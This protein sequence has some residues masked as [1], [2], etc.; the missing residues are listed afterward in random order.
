MFRR[1]LHS[2]L[3]FS[4]LLLISAGALAQPCPD[5]S[6]VITGPGVVSNNQLGVIYSTPNIPGHTYAWTVTGGTIGSGAG[7]NQITVNWGNIGTGTITLTETNPAANCS[8]TVNKSVSIRPL[9]I[10]YF[11]YTNTSC[12]GD[13]VSF[14]DASVADASNPV[15]TWYWTFGD[16][17]TST[18]QNPQHQYMSPFNVTYTVRLVVTNTTAD[19]DTIIDA[20]YVN[21]DQFIPHPKFTSVI[22]NCLYTPVQFNST[23]STTPPGTGNIIGWDWNFDDPASGASNTSTLQN[24][25]HVFTAPGTYLIYLQVTNE[26][27]CNN[28]TTIQIIIEP[29]LPV[30][31]Y[32]YSTPTCLDNPIYF[33]DLSTTPPGR[34]MVT[35]IWNFGDATAPVVINAPNN[36]DIVHYFPGLGPYP[37]TITVINNLG[38]RDSI[39]KSIQ[40]DPSPLADFSY[41]A[42]CVGDTVPFTNLSIQN[43]G[44]EIVS[45]Y[46]NFDDPGSGFNTSTLENP[47]HLFSAVD[48]YDVMLVT[49]NSTGCPDTVIKPVIVFDS[50]DVDFTWNFGSQNNEIHFHIDTIVTN[51]E[52]IGDMCLWNFGDGDWGYGHNP[53]H[54]YAAAGTFWVTLFVTDTVGCTN[55]ITYPVDVPSVPV[56]FFSSTSPVCDGQEVCFT[57]LSSV[58]SPPFGYIVTWIW[59]YGDVSPQD[60]INFPDDPN[61]CHL[62]ATADTFAVTLKVIDNN[63]YVDSTTANVIIKPNPIANFVYSTACQNQVVN[64]TDMSTPNGGGNI[65]SWD[66]NFA[67]PGSGINNTSALQNPTHAFSN[68]DS[69]YLVRLIIVNFNDCRDTIIKPVYVFPA[70]PVDFTHDT[71]CLN[72]LVTFT[73]DTTVTY[74]DSIATWSWD[75]GDGTPLVTDPITTQHLYTVAGVYTVTLSVIDYHGCENSVSHTV[76]V[77]PLPVANY[78][79]ASP[80]CQGDSVLFTDQSY[81]PPGFTGYIAKWLWDFGDGITQTIITPASPNVYHTFIGPSTTFTVRLTVWSNDSC[82]MFIEQTVSLIPAPDANFD[83]SSTNCENQPVGF[84]DLSQLNGGGQITSWLWDFGDPAS[85]INNTSTLQNPSHTY[86]SSGTYSVILAVTNVN[87]CTDTILKDVV[88]NE[89]PVPDFSA[90]TAC[91]GS[92][93]VFTDLS[94]SDTTIISYSWDFGDGSPLSTQP[95]PTHTYVSYGT[96]TVTLTIINANGCISSTA[97]DVMVNPLPIPEFSYSTPNCFGAPVTFTNQSTTV[98]GYMGNIITWVWDF[99]DG[100]TQTINY[101][102]NP[103]VTHTFVGAALS[104]TVELTVTT[105][106]GCSDSIEHIVNS[107]P[108]PIA[109]FTFPGTPCAQNLIPFTDLSQTNGGGTIVQWAWNF[110]DPPSGMNN[111]STA[112]NPSHSFTSAGTYNVRLIVTNT[113]GCM[114]TT[115]IAVNVNARPTADFSADTACLGNMT[116]FT[117]LSSTTSGVIVSWLWDFGDGQTGTGSAPTH[118]YA[119]AGTYTV[120]LAVTTS[121]GCTN[122]TTHQVIVY[123]EVTAAFSYNSPACASDSVNF[124][125]LSNSPHGSITTWLWDF[126]DGNTVTVNFPANPNVSHMYAD[127]G[128]YT[129]SLTITTSDGCTAQSSNPV[130][131]NFAP[132]ANFSF[133]AGGCANLGL[134]F[135]DLSQENGGGSII[136]WNWDFGDPTTGINNYSTLQNPIHAFSSG[137]TFNV[138]L[139]VTNI[140]G[141]IDS[142]TNIVTISDAPLS[143]FSADTACFDAPTSF[144][145]EST[146]P[147]GTIIAW[148]WNFGDPASGANNTSTLQ[149]PT[150]IFTNIGV[151]DVIL[152]VTNSDG[153][154]DDTTMQITVNPKPIAQFDYTTACLGSE[155]Q[156]T[157]LSIAP[158]S[159]ITDWFWD[160]GDGVGTSDIQN[161]VYVY[162]AAG[163]YDVTLIVTNLENC[164]DSVVV[165]VDV[166][167]N[168]TAAFTYLN[169]FCP[170]G[171]VNFQDES[172]GAG[173]T[174]V[175]RFWTFEPGYT[176]IEVN[177]VH[178]FTETDTTYAVE[179]IVTDNF[180]CMDTIVDSV[181][182]KPGMEFTFTNDTVCYGY[183]TSFLTQNLASGDSLYSVEWNFGDPASAPNNISYLYNPTHTFSAAGIYIV[184]LKAWNSDNCVDS[185]Y[186]EVTVYELPQPAFSFVS[187]PCDSIISFTDLSLSGANS[188]LSWEWHFGDGSPPEIIPAPGPGN[189]THGYS[190]IGTYLV[191]LIVTNSNGCVDSITDTIERYPC[192]NAVFFADPVLCARSPVIFADSSYPVDKINQWHWSFGDGLDTTYTVYTDSVS[193]E[194]LT[195]GDYTV[196][197]TINAIVS[198]MPFSDSSSQL[199]R[200]RPTPEPYFSN[201]AI[202]YNQT[203]MFLDTSVTFGEPTTSWYWNFGEPA[204]GTGDTSTLQDPSHKYLDPGLYDVRMI[205]SNQY[206]CTDSITKE[207]R[208][209]GV[210]EAMFES[211]IACEGNP[212]YF[213]D[214]SVFTDTTIG[215]WK[216]NF[217]VAGIITDT[218]N[219]QDPEY[220]YSST[221]TYPVRLIV[222]DYNGCMDTVDSTVIVNVTPLSA[223]NIREYIDGLNGKLEMQNY[224]IGANSYIWNFGNGQSS[225]EEN[226]VITYTEDG[227]YIIELISLN[228]FGCT[229]TTYFEYELLFKGL[230]IPNAFAPTSSNLAVR[231]FKPVGINLKK[232]HIQVFNT[233]GHLMWESTKLDTQGRPEEAWDGSFNG[234]LMPQ[235]NYMWKVSATF[236][237]NSPWEGSDIGMGDYETIGTLT[238]IR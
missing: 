174:I 105:N 32:D 115:I 89:G 69:T 27:Y 134:Q 211:T 14:W 153:C 5:N 181:F 70:P 226:P 30:A 113:N 40:L 119:N 186:R 221:G 209:F 176:S 76:R 193:H 99:G 72:S 190:T 41:E 164:I 163:T 139:I 212:T 13:I 179:L 233:S 11:Y 38:C 169:F 56:A 227:T 103:N 94:T 51:L 90:D 155:T 120:M 112:Q 9:L 168:P 82:S 180:G 26:R 31:E 79:W 144:T 187:E 206:G 175:E 165:P 237:D 235:G 184:K 47:K 228:E 217:G 93:T 42:A 24:P 131:I 121:E 2:V 20:V 110:D 202:C 182:V 65:I 156:F 4:F 216:W 50:P 189:T 12:Y 106:H 53:I 126:G 52:M 25:S 104:H 230:Y 197:L 171:Q 28:D 203:T 123:P 63:G 21:P 223:F 107:I 37:T 100:T 98:P 129:V 44:P 213:T 81:I 224:S 83:Y 220:V 196:V 173:S 85:G 114:D 142:L 108:A 141:C 166:R 145:D 124:V 183:T 78:T 238:L 222:Q 161:P 109:N 16:G 34:D 61:V 128:T 204:S 178:T 62:Y 159:S 39:S 58:P 150:H 49:V 6:P 201:V 195:F 207:T 162:T 71:A 158:G 101:P 205:V 8:T 68:G 177:P 55:E 80:S 229:D 87:N 91:L 125:D 191:T 185:I 18:L 54:T 77:N 48:I 160:F 218:S 132:I 46:W 118:L 232:F 64:F 215:Y 199:I 146:T 116:T 130:T 19:K 23:T 143:D 138:N 192:I 3:A 122:D 59:D 225:T 22:P 198:G 172:F 148:N 219:I 86:S 15:V 236:I 200:I 95:S 45:Y 66:W 29:S 97:E 214:M 102:A 140:N 188:I 208:V 111:N 231:L 151:F 74:L 60:T 194:Y 136:S 67:D 33:T 17:G 75:F 92:P 167:E 36:P 10:S 73:A 149:N 137:G 133:E 117:D 127:G 154:E 210:P 147:T 96:Y 170:A 35:W 43:N 152:I 135:T 1:F 7:T 157:D 84:T 88:I 57:D 234:E